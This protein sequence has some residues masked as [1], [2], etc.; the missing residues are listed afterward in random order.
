MTRTSIPRIASH[1]VRALALSKLPL[2]LSHSLSLSFC[3][4]WPVSV[5][6]VRD[7][8]RYLWFFTNDIFTSRSELLSE[9]GPQT[10]LKLSAQRLKALRSSFMCRGPF[11]GHADITSLCH[12]TLSLRSRAVL[13]CSVT[14]WCH[15]IT[16]APSHCYTAAPLHTN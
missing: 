13:H 8:S 10:A 7:S 11:P 3:A 15:S 1:R 9:K 12:L 5:D 14:S 4:L 6:A 16:A 2:S